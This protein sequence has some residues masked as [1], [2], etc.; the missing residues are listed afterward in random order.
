VVRRGVAGLV[1]AELKVVGYLASS[2]GGSGG[3][4]S[5]TMSGAAAARTAMREVALLNNPYN[6]S[7]AARCSRAPPAD[8]SMRTP[9]PVRLTMRP[10]CTAMVGSI[11]SLRSARRRASVRSSS[12]PASLLNP[13][14][15]A[16]R[17]LRVSGSPPWQSSPHARLARLLIGLYRLLVQHLIQHL[18]QPPTWLAKAFTASTSALRMPA[19]SAF[20]WIHTSESCSCTSRAPCPSIEAFGEIFVAGQHAPCRAL[21]PALLGLHHGDVVELA[22]GL[23]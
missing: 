3:F 2:F 14:T 21:V 8:A 20:S 18:L 4:T 22:T 23:A 9:S 7:R 11:R 10:L 15:S 16:A 17:R 6:P 13:T 1:R 5:A 19:R 12:D